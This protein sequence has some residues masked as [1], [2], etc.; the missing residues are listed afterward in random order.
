META[1]QVSHLWGT[2]SHLQGRALSPATRPLV[3]K[4]GTSTVQPELGHSLRTPVLGTKN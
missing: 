3:S 1:T 4:S 2:E